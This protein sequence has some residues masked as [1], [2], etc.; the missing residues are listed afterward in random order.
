MKC[1]LCLAEIKNYDPAFNHFEINESHSAEICQ[2]CIDKL[3]KWQQGIYAGLFPTKSS[4][5]RIEKTKK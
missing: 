2:G 1:N 3:A 4:K 5:K